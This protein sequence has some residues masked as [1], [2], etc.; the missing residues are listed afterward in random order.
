MKKNKVVGIT[1][2]S[3]D[4]C[5]YGHVLMFEECKQFCDYLIVGVQSDPSIDRPE[6]N[7]PIQSHEERL[8]LVKSIKYVD[9]VRSYTTES[10]LIELLKEINPDLRI[11]GADHKGTRFTGCDLDIKNIFNSRDHGFST[12]E[13]RNRVYKAEKKKLIS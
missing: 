10:S 6:K 7:S 11:L 12:S 9:E 8:G 1:F 5:H 3:F 13:L 2:G 4:L